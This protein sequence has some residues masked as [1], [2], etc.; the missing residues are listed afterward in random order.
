MGNGNVGDVSGDGMARE[1]RLSEAF[2]ALVDTQRPAFDMGDLLRRLAQD[3]VELLDACASRVLLR[4]DHE[5]LELAAC[6]GPSTPLAALP[7]PHHSDGPGPEAYRS[8]QPV[9]CPDLDTAPPSWRDLATPAR[10]AGLLGAHAWP[11]RHRDEILGAVEVYRATPTPFAGHEVRRGVA[12]A[13]VATISILRERRQQRADTLAEQLQH[14]LDSRLVIE[15]AKGILAERGKV[16]VDQAFL[17]LRGYARRRQMRIAAVARQVIDGSL[18]GSLD[19][20]LDRAP[21]PGRSRTPARA[22]SEAPVAY[23][24]RGSESPG[25]HSRQ[26]PLPGG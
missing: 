14:A 25:E 26:R 7:D 5:Q 9:A 22:P 17:L 15:Q 8:G 20:S 1:R 3:C 18:E 2:V 19:E 16:D 4:D 24:G 10:A 6:G 23:V 21:G 13:A 11:L 12:L